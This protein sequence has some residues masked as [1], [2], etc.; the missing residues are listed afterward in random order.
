M[1]SLELVKAKVLF[2]LARRRNWGGSHTAFDNLKRGFKPKDHE[3]VKQAAEE[4]IKEGLIWKKVTGYG[5]HVSLNHEKAGEIKAKIKTLL[6]IT[7][8]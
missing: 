2:K 7:T 4:L 5:L 3:R 6:G 8:D 1:D